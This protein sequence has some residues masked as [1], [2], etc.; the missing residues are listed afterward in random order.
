MRKGGNVVKYRIRVVSTG[1][2]TSSQAMITNRD[3]TCVNCRV[4]ETGK[5]LL[6]ELL[7]LNSYLRTKRHIVSSPSG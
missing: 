1:I 6:A 3:V 2:P 7:L 5:Y 4:Q